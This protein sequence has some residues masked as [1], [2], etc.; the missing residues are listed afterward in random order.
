MVSFKVRSRVPGTDPFSWGRRPSQTAI[1]HFLISPL[2][3]ALNKLSTITGAEMGTLLKS[4]AI[5]LHVLKRAEPSAL[6]FSVSCRLEGE[7]FRARDGIGK[8]VNYGNTVCCNIWKRIRQ[9]E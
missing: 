4:L 5:T 7:W 3:K 8:S 2:R 1:H 6:R 9:L